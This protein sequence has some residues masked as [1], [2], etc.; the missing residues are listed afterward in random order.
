MAKCYRQRELERTAFH[1]SG[2]AT[3]AVMMGVPFR[4]V[5]IVPDAQ[6]AGH[7]DLGKVKPPSLVDPFN[8]NW[9]VKAARPYWAARICSALAGALAETLYTR[10]WEQQSDSDEFAAWEIAD[11][12]YPPAKAA[13]WINRLRF[14]TLESLRMPDVQAAVDAVAQELVKRKTL[15]GAKVHSL[16]KRQGIGQRGTCGQR[17]RSLAGMQCKRVAGKSSILKDA[18]RVAQ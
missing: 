7:V 11:C 6:F 10:C 13:R 4:R 16:V 5:T 12:F 17:S 18:G 15:T 8:E 2:H 9:D 14:Q 3:I 1:E